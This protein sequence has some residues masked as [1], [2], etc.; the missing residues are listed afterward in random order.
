MKVRKPAGYTPRSMRR[1]GNDHGA[2][3]DK[4]K[5]LAFRRA[6]AWSDRFIHQKASQLAKEPLATAYREWNA[7]AGFLRKTAGAK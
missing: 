2:V 7:S 6:K 3:K 4:S 1:K 5:Q